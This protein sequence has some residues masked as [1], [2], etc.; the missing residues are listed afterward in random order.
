MVVISLPSLRIVV[1][2]VALRVSLVVLVMVGVV[3]SSLVEWLVVSSVVVMVVTGVA[4][5]VVIV[6][7]VVV[8]LVILV[9]V[10]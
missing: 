1:D 5:M 2:M 4:A 3:D 9:V 6:E 7:M 8:V 10:E